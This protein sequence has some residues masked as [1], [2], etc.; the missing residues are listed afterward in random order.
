LLVLIDADTCAFAP[1]ATTTEDD[2]SWV[3]T[4]RA[5][6]MV[7]RI[8]EATGATEFELWLTGKGNFRF[9]VYP[10]YKANRIGAPRPYWEPAVKD[11]LVER[12]GARYSTGCEADDMVGAR[13]CELNAI[14]PSII[15]HIDKDIDMIP[16]RHYNWEIKRNGSVVRPERLYEISELEAYYN[17]YYQMLIGDTVDNLKGVPGIG[18]KKAAGILQN[19]NSPQEMFEAVRDTYNN[20]EYMEMT[21]KC[22]W[23]WRKMND[24]WAFPSDLSQD[25]S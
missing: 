24:I 6:E 25:T 2:P 4:S 5:N 18:P 12:W 11:F 7:E 16:G 9:N 3:A 8:L 15:A 20:D 13:Q 17:F 19:C 21:G 14:S 22:L 23:I 1:A 10:E